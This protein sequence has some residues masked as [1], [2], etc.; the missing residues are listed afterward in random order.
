MASESVIVDEHDFIGRARRVVHRLLA[1]SGWKR[2]ASLGPLLPL[3]AEAAP[4]QFL[5]AV[6]QD[7][8]SPNP[9]LVELLR[10]E[11]GDAI[12]GAVYHTGVLWA[13][14]AL[15]WSTKYTATVAD[16]LAKLAALDPGGKW[17]NRP[18]ASLRNLFFSWRPQTMATFDELHAI[19]RQ[20]AEKQPEP[21]WKLLLTLLPEH[22]SSIMDSYKPSPWRSW[23][24]GWTGEVVVRDYWRYISGIADLALSLTTTDGSRWPELLD[25]STSLPPFDR[26]RI[27]A[28]LEQI[29]PGTLSDD[30]RLSLWEMLRETVQKHTAFHDAN[31]ALPAEE[32]QR[33][34]LI[35]D[36]F[37]PQDEIQ[38]GLPLFGEGQMMYESIG[39]PYEEREASLR[40]RQQVAVERIWSTDG[41][42][43]IL[44]L[45][46]QV[47]D[48]WKVGLALGEAKGAE[49][50]ARII[51][52]L[53]CSDNKQ[54]ESFAAGYAVSRVEAKGLDWAERIPT[55]QW[56]PEQIAAFECLMPF[57][58]R[59]W[60]R[61]ENAGPDVKR[62]YWTKVRAWQVPQEPTQLETAVR[63]LVEAGRP[64]AAVSLL[65]MGEYKKVSV[66][67]D[68]LFDVLE[69]M[70]SAEK[71][72]WQALETYYIQQ[73]IKQLQE[74]DQVDEARLGKLEFGFLPILGKHTLRAR[75][76]ERLLARDPHLFVDCLKILY[77]ARHEAKDEKPTERDAQETQRAT[78]VWRL[79]ND[80]QSIPGTQP[81][82]SISVS[83]LRAWVTAARTAAREVDRLEVCDI[84][85]GEVFA[86]APNDEAGVKPC[87]P[88]REIIE[89]FESDEIVHGFTIG[90][91]NLRGPRWKEYYEGGQKE[92]EIAAEYERYAK[93][94]ETAWPRTAAAL[95]SVAQSYL[96][97]AERE[98]AEAQMRE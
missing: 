95:R 96:R 60:E 30:Q 51:P 65:A 23:A 34:A 36:R 19:L 46:K 39:L 11:N 9:A 56:T 78:L 8:K 41:L 82:G 66:S 18:N 1:E 70:L 35:R 97:E 27:L 28:A 90:L 44:A 47:K 91:Y 85:I 69:A 62:H 64:S 75:T 89:A 76:L 79:L 53:L 81:D 6:A 15:G 52:D 88:V 74:D 20:L 24:A 7:L 98:D 54:I 13:L 29:N 5:G 59:T 80:W 94:C 31:W 33:L 17:A 26:A 43:G 72:E 14:E 57:D 16:L 68:L 58:S 77:R 67:S 10:N 32:V 12:T 50:E 61:V 55:P 84:K 93:A 92:R 38:I 49:P 87:L 42:S 22:H 86:H 63:K 71:E 83:E 4:E 3:L 37:A 2:W 73:F 40:Q 45:A 48:S 25:R 21:A